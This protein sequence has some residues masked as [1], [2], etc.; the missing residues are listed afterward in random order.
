MRRSRLVDEVFDDGQG[1]ERVRIRRDDQE[2]RR[3][4]GGVVRVGENRREPR[5]RGEIGDG[6][7]GCGEVYREG[8][9]CVLKAVG[10]WS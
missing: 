6:G 2:R 9:I 5:F 4:R 3:R 1:R 8:E 10:G 7:H